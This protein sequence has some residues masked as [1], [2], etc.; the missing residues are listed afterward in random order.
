MWMHSLT[1]C[2]RTQTVEEAQQQFKRNVI[3]RLLAE[4]DL[5]ETIERYRN[6]S[7]FDYAINPAEFSFDWSVVH[8]IRLTRR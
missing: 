6:L 2:R 5:D 3:R 4:F 7:A 1:A 8:A